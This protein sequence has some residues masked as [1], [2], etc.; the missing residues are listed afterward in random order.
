[1]G[2]FIYNLGIGKGFRIMTQNPG[3]IKEPLINLTTGKHFLTL[4]D[5]NTINKVKMKLTEWEKVFATFNT[6]KG[7]ISF[8]KT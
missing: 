4:T 6:E 7:L 8:V 2:K 3:A 5:K 1:M